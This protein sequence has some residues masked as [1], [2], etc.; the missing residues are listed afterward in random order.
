[1]APL[2]LGAITSS[3]FTMPNTFGWKPPPRVGEAVCVDGGGALEGRGVERPTPRRGA[4][5]R[6]RGLRPGRSGHWVWFG[7]AVGNRRHGWE[8]VCVD[9]GRG[10]GW[11]G[12]G[13][14]D[15]SQR[16][17]YAGEGLRPGP[18]LRE[19]LRRASWSGHWVWFGWAVGNRRH[20]RGNR[21]GGGDCRCKL[22]GGVVFRGAHGGR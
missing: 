8:A 21:C 17:R 10:V 7:W 4:A 6:G 12:G 1:M 22:E 13:T 19:T 14:A 5:T 20:G 2:S 9:G 11:E 16:R 18:I 3:A 15:A